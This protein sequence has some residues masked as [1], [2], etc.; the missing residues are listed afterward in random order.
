MIGK[1]E[2]DLDIDKAR[3][4]LRSRTPE[5]ATPAD[6]EAGTD[7]TTKVGADA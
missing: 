6:T 1:R 2:K 5:T 7:A 3:S 4:I